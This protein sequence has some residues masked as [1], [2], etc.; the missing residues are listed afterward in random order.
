MSTAWYE[1]FLDRIITFISLT[2]QDMLETDGPFEGAS[3]Y[4][5]NVSDFVSPRNS[6]SRQVQAIIGF[7]QTLKERYN[8]YLTV[9][10]PYELTSGVNKEPIG[11]TDTYCHIDS[12]GSGSVAD[13]W[14]YLNIG[15][16]YYYD[17]LYHYPPTGGWTTFDMEHVD[18]QPPGVPITPPRLNMLEWALAQ[19]VCENILKLIGAVYNNPSS[20][21][22]NY[23]I[24]IVTYLRICLWI[25]FSLQ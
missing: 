6:Q 21:E 19:Y 15:R 8:T 23:D 22:I 24:I 1:D 4:A 9:P 14:K 17:G 25:K 10:D 5:T 2:G 16:A 3:C 7:Y 12:S 20:T 18:N 11:Y 13:V